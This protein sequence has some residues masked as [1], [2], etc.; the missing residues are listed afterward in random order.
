M[1][2]P[3]LIVILGPT[4]SG[5]SDLAYRLC[6]KFYGYIISADSRQFYK[7]LD[8]A[9]AKWTKDD[10]LSRKN[11]VLSINGIA[12]YLIDFLEPTAHFSAPEFKREVKK[13]IHTADGAPF[14]VGGTGLYISSVVDNFLF[15]KGAP[16]ARLRTEL[17]REDYET[18]VKKLKKL[19]RKSAEILG[20]KKNKRRVV[21][22]LEVCMV[23]GKPF[24]EQQKKGKP[25]YDILQIGLRWEKQALYARINRRQD[26]QIAQGL[27]REIAALQA[28]YPNSP[29]AFSA[30]GCKE[31]L[32][33]LLGKESMEKAREKHKQNNRNYALKQMRWFKRDPRIHWYDGPLD[34]AAY[35]DIEK[36]IQTF[37][38]I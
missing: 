13:I 18:L 36:R 33:Y 16:N 35:K 26:Q 17:E 19:D 8:I 5:K 34:G 28:R 24:S 12:H 1:N 3:K 20:P 38:E 14:M 7:E 27:I 2:L 22:A 4:A 15:P 23:S 32:P 31:F 30:I 21:R 25:L 6:K 37:L 9:T 11:G 10:V 29:E